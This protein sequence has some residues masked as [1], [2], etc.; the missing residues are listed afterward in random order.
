MKIIDGFLQ[1]M[2]PTETMNGLNVSYE[3]QYVDFHALIIGIAYSVC[4]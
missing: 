2:W 4:P 1:I 3:K